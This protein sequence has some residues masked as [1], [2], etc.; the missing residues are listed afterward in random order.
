LKPITYSE[1]PERA[2]TDEQLNSKTIDSA[3]DMCRPMVPT[4]STE[5]VGEETE[6]ARGRF[7]FSV[8]ILWRLSVAYKFIGKSWREHNFENLWK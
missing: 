6:L 1:S 5:C 3:K 8:W 4:P 7:L 2:Q